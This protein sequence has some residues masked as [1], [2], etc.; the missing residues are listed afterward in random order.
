VKKKSPARVTFWCLAIAATLFVTHVSRRLLYAGENQQYF[1]FHRG[2]V[3]F[4]ALVEYAFY[5]EMPASYSACINHL[6]QLDGA[7]QQWALEQHKLGN[8]TPTWK[9][10]A[11]YVGRD[12]AAKP[13]DLPWCPQ[14][15]IY[16]LGK[17]DEAPRCT[18]PG[19]NLP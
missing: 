11:P 16:I 19:H 3:E 4:S 12:P 9:E 8:D 10:I 6:R 1:G 13:Q 17:V 7:K 15:G 2:Q 18:Y 5:L 14:G